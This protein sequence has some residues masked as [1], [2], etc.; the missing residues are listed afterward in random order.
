MAGS[1]SRASDAIQPKVSY[2]AGLI[3][4]ITVN[5]DDAPG[6]RATA[7]SVAAQERPPDEW[8]VIDGGSTDGSIAVIREFAHLIYCWT[9]APDR[10]VYDGMNRGLRRARGRYVLFMNAGDRFAGPDSVA[11]IAAALHA[12]PGVDLLFGGTILA[13][14]SGQRLYR[15]PRPI[16][17]LRH[18]LP[19]YHQ[20]TVIR[21]AAHLMAPYD[22]GLSISAEYGSIATLISRGA[23][24][25]HADRP[26]AIRACH[27]GSLSERATARRFAD[28]V[29][30]QRQVLYFGLGSVAAHVARLALVHFAYQVVG[31]IRIGRNEGDKQRQAIPT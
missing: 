17:R 25:T 30:V 15:P 16:A 9:S 26:L 6:L 29:A 5:L 2:V 22:L 21:R 31:R 4:V 7:L 12:S 18:G 13:L 28:F 1:A 27:P 19:A 14:P 20:A 24:S 10:G 11:R 23:S 3:S 8:I